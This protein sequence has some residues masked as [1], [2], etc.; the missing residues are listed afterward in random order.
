MVMTMAGRLV[1]WWR[2]WVAGTEKAHQHEWA[3]KSAW[4]RWRVEPMGES[5]VTHFVIYECVR[6][7]STEERPTA[8]GLDWMRDHGQR[9]D[10]LTFFPR[11]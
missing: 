4:G 6:C 1:G 9:R 5:R 2:R 8:A 7:G 11:G 10:G 3:R